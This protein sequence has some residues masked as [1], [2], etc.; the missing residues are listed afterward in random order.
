MHLLI[1]HEE[2]VLLVRILAKTLLAERLQVQQKERQCLLRCNEAVIGGLVVDKFLLC[3]DIRHY[4]HVL[5]RKAIQVEDAIPVEVVLI[6]GNFI[7]HPAIKTFIF[8][9]VFVNLFGVKPGKTLLKLVFHRHSLFHVNLS[10]IVNGL[11]FVVILVFFLGI[12]ILKTVRS[13][14][15]VIQTSRMKSFSIQAMGFLA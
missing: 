10:H 15:I 13:L 5:F 1:E 9:Q 4:Q 11:V 3:A 6:S 7:Y 2:S 14:V 12:R 8:W